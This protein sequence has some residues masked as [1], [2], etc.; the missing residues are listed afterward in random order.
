MSDI[1]IPK[2]LGACADRLYKLRED[3]LKKQKEVDALVAEESAIKNHIIDTLPR[4]E[5]SGVTGRVGRITIN[6][7][8]VPRVE[9]WDAFYKHIAKTKAFELLQRRVSDT[10]VKERWE[11]GKKVPGIDG[12]NVKYVSVTKA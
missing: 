6:E 2:T 1:K 11:D 3:R 10:A 7:K 4:S 5:A 9:D 8:V 12:F